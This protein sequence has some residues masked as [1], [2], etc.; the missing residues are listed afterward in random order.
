[1]QFLSV[2]D[3]SC[4]EQ[5]DFEI[6][7]L[8]V[9]IGPQG[10]GKSVITKL[11]YFFSD[12]LRNI[13]SSTEDEVN[14]NE[15]IKSLEKS[16]CSWF[17]PQA[18][19]SKKLLINYMD[20]DFNCRVM[21]RI[22]TGKLSDEVG[23]TLSA[24]VK[25]FYDSSSESFHDAR[26]QATGLKSA[27][28]GG[29][30][31]EWEFALRVRSKIERDLERRVDGYAGFNQTFIPAGRAFFTSIGRLVA[32]I[33]HAGSLDPATM[34][35]ARLFAGWRDHANTYFGAAGIKDLAEARKSAML[36][37]FNG[38]IQNKRDAE[39]IEMADGRKVPFASLS[40]GQQEMLPIWYFLDNL[41]TVDALRSSRM[42]KNSAP[43][44]STI[45]IEE[46]EAHLFPS[47]QA[48]LLDMLIARVIGASAG[49]QRR[50]IL[51]TH[52]PYI[53]SRL[54]VLL[55]AG[56]L[57]K[58]RR[59]IKEIGDVIPKES[60]V[61]TEEISVFSISNGKVNSIID[62][63]EGLIDARFLDYISDVISE[64]F[65]KLLDIEG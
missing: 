35:F 27:E 53:M 19:G 45:Y 30:P 44:K 9:F 11:L 65:S 46:P 14:Y 12:I 49:A 28:L 54:N 31:Y 24:W 63:E 34:K 59:R 64:D 42:N 38:T 52:S 62:E 25:E 47:S 16:F 58:R 6:N 61:T 40:S 51:T 20:G 57:G 21:R 43:E 48:L 17:P 7:R 55:K 39:Y 36:G 2:K 50:L 18:W 8:T 5:A 22:K 23:I 37:L 56:Q 33:E 29:A 10:S 15:F 60:W 1:M 41:M 3:F 26:M 13:L 4:I 32:G